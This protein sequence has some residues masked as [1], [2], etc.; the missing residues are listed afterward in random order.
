MK[1]PQPWPWPWGSP[2]GN[3]MHPSY[4]GA[5]SSPVREMESTANRPSSLHTSNSLFRGCGDAGLSEGSGLRSCVNHEEGSRWAEEKGG[6]SR[7]ML[8]G[9]LGMRLGRGGWLEGRGSSIQRDNFKPGCPEG[10]IV[11]QKR[12]GNDEFKDEQPLFLISSTSAWSK[13]EDDCCWYL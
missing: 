2:K 8:K 9:K 3:R 10:V 7:W 5:D 6:R 12:A 11:R 1:C 4:L 13:V